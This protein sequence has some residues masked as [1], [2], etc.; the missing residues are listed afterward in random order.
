M[1]LIDK[2]WNCPSMHKNMPRKRKGPFSTGMFASSTIHTCRQVAA[3]RIT[4][5]Q[6]QQI[7]ACFSPN[8][9]PMF[10][11]K[12][13][14]HPSDLIGSWLPKTNPSSLKTVCLGFSQGL[15]VPRF[16][17]SAIFTGVTSS[18]TSRIKINQGKAPKTRLRFWDHFA[19]P[20]GCAFPPSSS[21]SSSRP[22]FHEKS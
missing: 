12:T 9:F 5:P 22:A 14:L 6:F 16:S 21:L 17:L 1:V 20:C 18:R 10:S 13:E 15:F 4:T 11:D 19:K 3:I 2:I 8:S 7:Q